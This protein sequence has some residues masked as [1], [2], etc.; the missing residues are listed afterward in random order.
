MLLRKF[1]HGKR[2]FDGDAFGHRV[3]GIRGDVGIARPTDDV[4]GRSCKTL[5]CRGERFRGALRQ[6][7][8]A[9]VFEQVV[10]GVPRVSR[11][12][13]RAFSYCQRETL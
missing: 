13:N 8:A 2:F 4:M 1:C 9:Q 6:K 3:S 10:H 11:A 7:A 12:T 5:R